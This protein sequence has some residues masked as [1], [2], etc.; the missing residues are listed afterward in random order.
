M[1]SNAYATACALLLAGTALQVQAQPPWTVRWVTEIHTSRDILTG[2]IEPNT[3]NAHLIFEASDVIGPCLYDE[4]FRVYETNGLPL[5]NLSPCIDG[6]STLDYYVTS[7]MRPGLRTDIL[8][9][10]NLANPYHNH[11]AVGFGQINSVSTEPPSYGSA[12]A[13]CA[14]VDGGT[15]YVGGFDIDCP[16]LV[17]TV[18]K[19]GGTYWR[20]CLPNFIRS[21]EATED[22]ILAITY[23]T[24]YTLNK[25]TGALGST[26]D[27]FTGAVSQSGKSHLDGDSLYWACVVSGSMRV[28]KYVLGQGPEW[29]VSLPSGQA[30]VGLELD[31]F[32][33][34]WTAA[35]TSLFWVNAMDGTYSS[36][37]QSAVI[38]TMDMWAGD[39]LLTGKLNPNLSIMFK[40]TSTP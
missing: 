33:R 25:E 35:W 14:F 36:V 21:Y 12:Q 23:P 38:G 5:S 11:I 17:G 20:T 4:T 8:N 40:A 7:V 27:L 31:A 28:G 3:G 2:L 16:P 32:G 30:P 24:V 37:S 34:L 26:F 29:T 18:Y 6:G 9:V 15:L 1:L 13:T 19:Q 10:A 22:S 39:L